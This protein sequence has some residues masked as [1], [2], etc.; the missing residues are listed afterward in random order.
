MLYKVDMEWFDE[1]ECAGAR[2][3]VG[4]VEIHEMTG[5]GA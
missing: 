4:N 5:N 3:S 2:R 1:Q